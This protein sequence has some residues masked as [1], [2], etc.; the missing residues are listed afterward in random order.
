M[1]EGIQYQFAIQD[2]RRARRRASMEKILSFVTGKSTDLLS[3]EDVRRKLKVTSSVRRGLQEI[4][5]EAIVGSVG[6]YADFTRT[7]LPK[8]DSDEPRWVSINS[9]VKGLGGVPPIEVFQINDAYFVLD[10]NH[11]VSVARD[12]GAIYIEAYVTEVTTRVP[13]SKDLQADELIL[14]AGYANFLEQ[15]QIDRY[16]PDIDF[17]VTAPGKY[18][19]LS[20]YIETHRQVLIKKKK[21]TVPYKKAVIDWYKKI[22]RPVAKIIRQRGIL[23]DFPGRTETD[24]F[25]WIMEHQE[26]LRKQLGW[27]I[28]PEV[29]ASDLVG[30][31]SSRLKRVS[32]RLGRKL[33]GFVTLADFETG[34][35]PGQ[36][37]REEV[38]PR[39]QE[40]LFPS[41]LVPVNGKEGGW[42]ALKQAIEIARRE[43]GRL[44]GLYVVPSKDSQTSTH[45][46][47]VK[48]EFAK[49]CKAAGIPGELAIVPGKVALK[50]CRRA[51]WTDLVVMNID[52]PPPHMFQPLARLRSSLRSLIQ[53]CPR[54]IFAVSRMSTAM[55][56]ALLAYDG[57]PKSNEA[58]FVS[59]YIAGAFNIPL[60]VVTVTN[61]SRAGTDLLSFAKNYLYERQIKATF[62]NETGSVRKSIMNIAQ[63]HHC[64]LLIMGGYGRH[65]LTA[66]LFG[67]TIEHILR[68]KKFPLLICR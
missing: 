66:I 65:P 48:D 45:A 40:Q 64:D 62:I 36:W 44:Y 46:L 39:S 17:S 68:P 50:I 20:D 67:S 34:P 56:S 6:R 30:R 16:L 15:T 14:K 9:R 58:L 13:M 57:S 37:R 54:P 53:R 32:S 2:F 8:L 28:T 18:R 59:A 55:T 31:F 4:P 24:M 19:L 25:L 3:Y 63:K 11:R 61:I 12:V 29:A 51:R 43:G 27:K 10:G 38:L 23:R 1:S 60:V 42:Y 21:Y 7:F 49:R 41:I 52:Y 5:L 33:S 26:E 35:V 47:A 22:Y